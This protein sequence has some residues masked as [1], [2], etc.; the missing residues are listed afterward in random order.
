MRTLIIIPARAGSK[1]LPGKNTKLLGGLPLISHTLLFAKKIKEDTD[2][3]CVST[4]DELVINIAKELE[5][6]VP[7]KRPEVLASDR[8]GTYEVLLHALSYYDSINLDF[9]AVL[10]MQPTSPFRKE[11][12]FI[13]LKELYDN[14]CDMVVAVKNAKENPYFTLFE[15]KFDGYLEISKVADFKT[16]QEC[17]TVYAYNGS[18]YLIRTS[19]LRK[20]NLAGFRKIKKVVMPDE[21]SIDIDT[22]Q[23]WIVAEYFLNNLDK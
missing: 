23:D 14:K 16:R 1:G 8:A 4:N 20:S 13:K 15:E 12:D 3:I 2:V 10:L 18:M 22:I 6:E 17:P 7:F 21:R 19:S 9:D 5:I 11:E